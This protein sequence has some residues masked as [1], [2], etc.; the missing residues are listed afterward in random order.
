MKLNPLVALLSLSALACEQGRQPAPSL[1]TE[2]RDSAGIR[3]V[4][5]PKPPD[6]SRLPWSIGA[7]PIVSIGAVEG[8]EPYLLDAA[9]D[10]TRLSDGRIVILNGGTNELRVFDAS[11]V[12]LESWGG[13]GEGPGEFRSLWRVG[14]WP[15][16]SIIAWYAPRNG[17]SVF[18]GHGNYGRTLELVHDEATPL[19]QRFRPEDTTRDGS[20]V[21]VHWPH[22]ADTV[23]FQLRDGDG[24]IRSSLGT[25]PGPEPYLHAEGTDQAMLFHKIFGR[26]PVWTP[27]GDL[28]VVG[29]TSRYEFRAF[30]VDGSLAR[31]V[32]RDHVPRSP[33]PDD[34]EA[35]IEARVA[36]SVLRET[37]SEKERLRRQYQSVPV[38]ENFPTSASII[39]DAVSHLWVAEY[40]L[41]GEERP[42]RLWTVFDPEGRVLGFVETPEGLWIHEIGED[43]ILG[44]TWDALHVE[45][46][47]LW[48]LDRLEG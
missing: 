14:P 18:D 43:Y 45:Y 37:E 21:T 40:E 24:R 34:V 19:M 28:V 8:E 12:H 39:S 11:G 48:P 10:A 5:N 42:P 22:G 7:E 23:V 25:H 38:A 41:S 31:I 32:R 20:I 6:G 13:R 27:W 2:T 17:I 30:G 29:H 4:E 16:D 46:I 3:I 9:M 36:E 33:T 35:Y 15:G 1:R 26:E 44:T 47:Q